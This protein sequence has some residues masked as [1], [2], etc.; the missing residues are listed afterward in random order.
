M[1]KADKRNKRRI[2]R[3]KHYKSL[4]KEDES[5][6]G[7]STKSLLPGKSKQDRNING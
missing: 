1:L 2:K 4:R 7:L 3:N 6:V 5:F